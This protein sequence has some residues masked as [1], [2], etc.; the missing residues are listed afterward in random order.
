MASAIIDSRYQEGRK[1]TKG[2]IIR[3]RI[4]GATEFPGHVSARRGTDKNKREN[5]ARDRCHDQK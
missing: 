3:D 1:E 2:G 5:K 4:V